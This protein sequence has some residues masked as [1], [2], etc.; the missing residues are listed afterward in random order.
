MFSDSIFCVCHVSGS[1]LCHD[2][3]ISGCEVVIEE[4][5]DS[6]EEASYEDL[7]VV[8]TKSEPLYFGT[9]SGF[10]GY[11]EDFVYTDEDGVEHDPIVDGNDFIVEC[12]PYVNDFGLIDFKSI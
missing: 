3:D 9:I 5:I 2:C 11:Q 1:V 8:S 6:H 7:F 4:Y 12:E 10:V